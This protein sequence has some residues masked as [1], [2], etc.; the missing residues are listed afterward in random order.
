ML[1]FDISSIVYRPVEKHEQQKAFDLWCP[2]FK[3][4][5]DVEE[6]YFLPDTSPRYQEGDTLGAWHNDKLVST[7]HIRRFTLRSSENN[8]EYLCAGIGNVATVAEYRRQGLSRHL[9]QMAV[10]KMEES[11]EFDISMLST[12]KPSHYASFGWE[13]VPEPTQVMIDWKTITSSSTNVEWR[14]ASDVLCQDIE[15]M[16][17]IHSNSPRIYQIDRSPPSVFQHW[18]KGRWQNNAAIVCLYEHEQEQG[19]VVI[20]K[21]DSEKDVCVLEWRAPNM[22]L[23]QKLLSLAAAEIRQR[24]GST[25]PIHLFALPQYMSIDELTEWAGSVQIGINLDLMM[26]NIRLPTDVYEKIKTAYSN[27]HAVFWS[28]DYF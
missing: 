28:G 16:L 22:K 19:Y 5:S 15:L 12:G 7:V 20:G 27:G 2:T 6:R 21:P 8:E 3:T 26:R 17:K 24:H 10:D 11:N 25:K 18:V 14:S 23:E 4:N 1:T 9:L 13:Q